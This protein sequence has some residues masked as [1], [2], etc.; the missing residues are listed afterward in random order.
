MAVIFGKVMRER[1]FAIGSTG[2]SLGSGGGGS[3]GGGG[4]GGR[5]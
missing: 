1:K 2:A 5:G 4:G 3:G